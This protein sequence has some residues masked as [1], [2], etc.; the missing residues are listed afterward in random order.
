MFKTFQFDSRMW[1]MET[2]IQI[3]LW[4][5]IGLSNYH[6]PKQNTESVATGMTELNILAHQT[7]NPEFVPLP[8]SEQDAVRNLKTYY[9][10][11]VIMVDGGD[12]DAG[13]EV[14]YAVKNKEK[15]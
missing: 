4:I 1:R 5:N 12:V 8:Q 9:P 7:T 15:I 11:T 2:E 6:I 14:E 13:I 10:T 3:F